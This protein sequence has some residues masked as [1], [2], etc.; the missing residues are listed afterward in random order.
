[1]C[2]CVSNGNSVFHSFLNGVWSYT[3]L[4]PFSLVL[5]AYIDDLV[6]SC[7]C[8]RG[9]YLVLYADDIRLLSAI[10]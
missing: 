5:V 4:S 1:M 9:V 3:R 10:V 2:V 8:T 6:N 7:D